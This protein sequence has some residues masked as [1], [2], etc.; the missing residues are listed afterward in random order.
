[1]KTIVRASL[2]PFLSSFIFIFPLLSVR[3]LGT[4]ARQRKANALR[5]TLF[6][7]IPYTSIIVP[8]LPACWSAAFATGLASYA[9]HPNL[10]ASSRTLF[11]SMNHP[12]S[13][14]C[15]S[16]KLPL[17]KSL[18]ASAAELDIL[19]LSTSLA[20]KVPSK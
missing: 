6:P 16:F 5:S 1:M 9:R 17:Q 8:V 13:F 19:H 18:I 10:S 11:Q 20:F 15:L 2:C 7:S 14:S 4:S 3:H 12:T